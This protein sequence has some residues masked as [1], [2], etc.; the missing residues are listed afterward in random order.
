MRVVE[1]L[2]RAKCGSVLHHHSSCD[3][4]MEC[5]APAVEQE[6]E[7][8]ARPEWREPGGDQNPVGCHPFKLDPPGVRIEMPECIE[9]RIGDLEE[10]GD[11]VCVGDAEDKT[12]GQVTKQCLAIADEAPSALRIWRPTTSLPGVPPNWR[13]R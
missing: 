3:D 5:A 4:V 13:T 9:I 10:R 6:Q 11:R 8:Q 12:E 2:F 1:I 7:L